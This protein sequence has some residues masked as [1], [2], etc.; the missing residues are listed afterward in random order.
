MGDGRGGRG[1]GSGQERRRS[2]RTALPSGYSD[3]CHSQP[4]KR[5]Q[6]LTSCP[7]PA[8]APRSARCATPPRATAWCASRRGA[9]SASVLKLAAL[10]PPPSRCRGPQWLARRGWQGPLPSRHGLSYPMGG[11]WSISDPHI[12]YRQAYSFRYISSSARDHTAAGRLG[13]AGRGCQEPG[14]S[15]CQERRTRNRGRADG[16]EEEG[17]G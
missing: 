11:D 5:K 17:W 3:S 9:D 15:T 13:S 2:T 14:R 8:A 6:V 1:R 7:S 4:A 16:S 10:G 12:A